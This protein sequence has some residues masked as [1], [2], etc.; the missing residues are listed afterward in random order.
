MNTMT[1]K[2]NIKKIMKYRYLCGDRG[3]IHSSYGSGQKTETMNT[4]FRCVMF[5]SDN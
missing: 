1:K 3:A 4:D 5:I 2:I